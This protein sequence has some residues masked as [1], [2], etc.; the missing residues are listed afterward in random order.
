MRYF[1]NMWRLGG[2]LVCLLAVAACS[3]TSNTAT[4]S[5]SSTSKTPISSTPMS[6]SSGTATS[7]TG[8]AQTALC[9]GVSTINQALV[10]LSGVSV[11][12]TVGDVRAAQLKVVNAVYAIHSRVPTA[13]GTLLSQDH[14]SQRPANRQAR[15]LPRLHCDRTYLRDCPGRQDKGIRCSGQYDA[16]RRQAE[17]QCVVFRSSL[18]CRLTK[19]S[20]TATLLPL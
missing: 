17:L 16:A 3:G 1:H 11:D 14:H 7:A 13:D 2:L 9:N 19:A 10:S 8:G 4:T 20:T 18:C 6:S 5:S 15:R 12:T